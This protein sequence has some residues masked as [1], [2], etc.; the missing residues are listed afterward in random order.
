MKLIMSFK[1]HS[2][3][4]SILTKEQEFAEKRKD[5]EQVCK[6]RVEKNKFLSNSEINFKD[7]NMIVS[8]DIDSIIFLCNR[9]LDYQAKERVYFYGK[10]DKNIS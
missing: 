6:C 10:T 2:N 9:I 7:E 3:C 8:L 5:Y 1:E 4:I